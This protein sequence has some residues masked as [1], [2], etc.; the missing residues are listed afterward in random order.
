MTLAKTDTEAVRLA[1]TARDAIVKAKSLPELRDI[2]DQAQAIAEYFKLQ[3]ISLEAQNEIATTKLLAERKL[4]QLLAPQKAGNPELSQGKRIATLPELGIDHNQSS[5]W[6]KEA[7]VPEEL[8]QEYLD[9][10]KRTATRSHR[11]RYSVL[12]TR[13]HSKRNVS[14]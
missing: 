1:R 8:F 2:R 13:S 10:N 11:L 9:E 7:S 3:G 4:G 6:K 14:R 5:R 12:P